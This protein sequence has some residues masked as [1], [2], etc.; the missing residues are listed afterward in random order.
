[1]HAF[2]SVAIY[3]P[4][5]FLTVVDS[6]RYGD[7][8]QRERVIIMVSRYGWALPDLPKPTY[9]PGT[10]NLLLRTPRDA[11]GDLEDVEP[12]KTPGRLMLEKPWRGLFASTKVTDHNDAIEV[13]HH[14]QKSHDGNH[15]IQR[16]YSDT[17]TLKADEPANTVLCGHAIKHYSKDRAVTNLETARLQSFPDHWQ[18]AGNPRQVQKQIGNAVPVGLATA[19]AREI[20]KVYKLMQDDSVEPSP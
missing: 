6:S 17:D 2:V 14:V 3:S 20:R 9:G 11:I 13:D 10:P 15:P 8:Q 1:M 19:I 12:R 7:P 18:F 4:S 16:E 5:L